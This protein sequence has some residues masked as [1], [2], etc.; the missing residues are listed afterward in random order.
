VNK[1]LIVIGVAFVGS[2]GLERSSSAKPCR[3]GVP[4]CRR[5]PPPPPPPPRASTIFE[6]VIPAAPARAL[7]RAGVL[8]LLVGSAWT[9][10]GSRDQ[11]RFGEAPQ[12][13]QFAR[14]PDD[15]DR[16]IRS[17]PPQIMRDLRVIIDGAIYTVTP[18]QTQRPA[19]PRPVVVTTTC[20][21]SRDSGSFG[22]SGYGGATYGGR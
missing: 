15:R 22:G 18:C 6:R 1:L 2:T 16:G 19:R 13:Q 14:P 11:I 10:R 12:G 7:D 8:R 5:P 3:A 21:E 17:V 4:D 20:L 9:R